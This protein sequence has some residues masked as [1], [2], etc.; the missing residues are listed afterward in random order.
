MLDQNNRVTT[1]N[2]RNGVHAIVKSV[3][4]ETQFDVGEWSITERFRFAAN[5]GEASQLGTIVSGPASFIGLVVAGPGASFS[6][7]NGPNAGQAIANPA[8]I[9]G[10]GL[11]DY[12]LGMNVKLN[13]LNT[14]TNDLRASRG[15]KIGGGTLTST[16]GVYYSSQNIDMYWSFATLVHDVAPNGN[17]ALVDVIA[18]N[19]TCHPEWGRRLFV[20]GHARLP[21]PVRCQLPGDRAL[22]VAELQDR[23]ARHRR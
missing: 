22:C 9:N 16:G 5:S 18:A 1:A 3:G 23:C 20:S 7:V 4:L 8:G 12:A 21:S 13:D 2:G 19:G 10:N 14:T 6:Y 11:L 17:S 15:W